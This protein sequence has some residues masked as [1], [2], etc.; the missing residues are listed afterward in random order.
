MAL[1]PRME[2]PDGAWRVDVIDWYGRTRYRLRYKGRL[3]QARPY[4][5]VEELIAVMGMQAF[6]Q[7]EAK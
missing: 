5:T 3:V 1:D 6:R 4:R 2:T 7:L